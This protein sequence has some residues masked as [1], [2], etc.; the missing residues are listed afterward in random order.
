[1]ARGEYGMRFAALVA[2]CVLAVG[3]ASTASVAPRWVTQVQQEFPDAE[4]IAQSGT[5]ADRDAAKNEA[6]ANLSF[7]FETTVNGRRESNYHSFESEDGAAY[8]RKSEQETVRE[9]KLTTATIL[10]AVAF[11]EPW[12][13]KQDK[14]WRCVAYIE[15]SASW[16]A[17]EPT[18]R[19]ARDTF[20]GFYKKAEASAE[21]FEKIRSL[22]MAREA[23]MD[24]ID[25]LSFAQLLS[26][27]LTAA[28]YTDSIAL[29]SSLASLQQAEKNRA[30]LF[31][32]VAGDS[33]RMVY[34]AVTKALSDAGFTVVDAASDAVYTAHTSVRLDYADENGLL[35]YRPSV[36]VAL[37]GSNGTVYSYAKDCKSV[38]AYTQSVGEKKAL[39]ALCAVI[40]DDFY[41][42]FT[43]AL[44]GTK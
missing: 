36:H 38:K 3:C 32:A 14:T 41:A 25:K 31:V 30:P 35:V 9:T 10:N 2:A 17:Y 18:L 24:F 40:D 22:G 1:M 44:R 43:S 28:A 15:R 20:A 7:Y 26:E 13:N 16:N 4:Y 19:V 8:V 11:T 23:G 21:P 27:P 12:Y 33:T 29:F 6:A 39:E 37:A 34:A 5:G 42:A